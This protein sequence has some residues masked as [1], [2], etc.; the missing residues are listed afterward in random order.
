MIDLGAGDILWVTKK[1][2]VD[3]G[4]SDTCMQFVKE[5][6]L[7]NGFLFKHITSSSEINSYLVRNKVDTIFIEEG[8]DLERPTDL[9]KYKDYNVTIYYHLHNS[10]LTA[11]PFIVDNYHG[12]EYDCHK[13]NEIIRTYKNLHNLY[14]CVNSETDATHLR[15]LG[16]SEERILVLEPLKH[17]KELLKNYKRKVPNNKILIANAYYYPFMDVLFTLANNDLEHEWHFAGNSMKITD[18]NTE[19]SKTLIPELLE[20]ENVKYHGFISHDELE[21]LYKEC[22]TYIDASPY[23]SWCYNDW[24]AIKYGC[25]LIH[26]DSINLPYSCKADIVKTNDNLTLH[27]L[28][29]SLNEVLKS[30]KGNGKIINPDTLFYNYFKNLYLNCEERT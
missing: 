22:Y 15:L 3:K 24:D 4:G 27:N 9:I 12:T 7:N 8:C 30:K 17:Y 5:L 10:V 2:G 18:N 6:L 23:Q 1:T 21:K 25:R 16:V 14:L 26:Y 20:K 11:N 28:V 29:A 13:L 19:L